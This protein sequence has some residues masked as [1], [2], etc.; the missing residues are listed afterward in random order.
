ML[1]RAALRVKTGRMDYQTAF[2]LI[3]L[4]G[5]AWLAYFQCAKPR[6]AR[7]QDPAVRKGAHQPWA[8][9]R[10]GGRGNR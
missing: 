9:D 2:F 5:A 10:S 3:A 8:D 1:V 6:P 7:K 4:A